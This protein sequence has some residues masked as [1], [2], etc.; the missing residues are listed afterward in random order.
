MK[1]ALAQV[2]TTI[3]DFEGNLEIILDY[4]R[5]AGKLG[6]DLVVFPEMTLT[7]YPPKDLLDRPDFVE[8]AEQAL[9]KLTQQIRQPACIVGFLGKRISSTGK[10]L[11]NAAALIHQQTILGV[12]HKMLLPTYDVFDEGRY[13]EPGKSSP[14]FEFCGRKIGVSICEDIWND[15]TYWGGTPYPLDPVLE[16]A[17]AGAE[18]LINISA[19]PYSRGKGKIRYELMRRQVL[20]YRAPLIYVNLVGGNDD[21]VFDGASQV[22]DAQGRLALRLKAFEE[23]LRVVDMDRLRSIRLPKIK[24]EEWVLDALV[25]GLK[26]YMKKCNFNKAVIGLSGGIDSSLTA[27][28]ACA[29]LGSKNVLGVSMPSP[30][31]SKGSLTDAKKLAQSLGMEYRV[32]PITDLYDSYKQVLD[33]DEG[34][35]VDVTLQNIQ[36]RIRGNILMA[37]SNRESRL[38]LSTGN[39]SEM[40]VGYCTLYGD[41]AGGL[42]IISDVPKTLVYQLAKLANRRKPAI[43]RSVF[44]KAPSAE[45]APHQK[46]QDDLPSYEILDGIL[47]R[48]IERRMDPNAIVAEG[49]ERKVVMDVLRRLDANEYKRGQAPPG[50]RI[51]TKAFGYG[52][53]FP[54]TSRYRVSLK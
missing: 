29:A 32:Y 34:K 43:P 39:K 41:M 14:V 13:F 10:P 51:T 24:E 37:L 44:S 36:A 23:D 17:E 27:W 40:S 28:I 16:Q 50:I 1:I 22:I 54:I 30:Y 6:A 11:T 42:A 31:S 5:R 47:E 49:F 26:D 25:M 35:K 15:P 9:K 20:R 52:W 2:N 12:K 19:S 18:I 53:R 3:G 38:L 45:L 48:Y 7:G 46:D 8:A 33:Y 21:L 4:V